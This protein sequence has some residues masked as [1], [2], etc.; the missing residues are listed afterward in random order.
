MLMKL[1]FC[2]VVF[3]HY[4]LASMP[5]MWLPFAALDALFFLAFWATLGVVKAVR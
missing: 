1:A 4:F 2:G 5:A 3:G